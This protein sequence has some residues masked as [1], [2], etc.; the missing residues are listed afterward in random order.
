MA[1]AHRGLDR[2]IADHTAVV[3]MMAAARKV[4]VRRQVHSP[5][6]D[7]HRGSRQA[8]LGMARPSNHSEAEV[9]LVVDIHNVA[10]AV[11]G[12]TV[13][14]V[15]LVRTHRALPAA[16]AA[17]L[18]CSIGLEEVV[19]DRCTVPKAASHRAGIRLRDRRSAMFLCDR[20]HIPPKKSDAELE[21]ALGCVKGTGPEAGHRLPPWH[22]DL[23]S[24]PGSKGFQRPCRDRARLVHWSKPPIRLLQRAHGH[25]Q[26]SDLAESHGFCHS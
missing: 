5:H 13:L 16:A 1:L 17:R 20:I 15:D 9:L 22:L 7:T 23:V 2:M 10:L 24:V 14:T 6:L 11:A 26:T 4:L 19:C 3:H 18:R 12:R 25:Q 8:A 21:R